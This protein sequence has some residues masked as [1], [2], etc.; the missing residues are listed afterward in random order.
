MA[1]KEEE[2][3]KVKKIK[4]VLLETSAHRHFQL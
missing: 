3:Q 1:T 4:F 2:E